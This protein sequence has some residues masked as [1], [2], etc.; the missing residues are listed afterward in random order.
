MLPHKAL[1][2]KQLI[3]LTFH[4]T[5]SVRRSRVRLAFAY[6]RTHLWANRD[7]STVFHSPLGRVLCLTS[8]CPGEELDAGRGAAGGGAEN[9][10]EAQ[11][12]GGFGGRGLM[13]RTGEDG[14]GR[15]RGGL[16][17]HRSRLRAWRQEDGAHRTPRFGGAR[18]ANATLPLKEKIQN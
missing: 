4:L 5:I 17:M 15:K 9:T 6:Q 2:D 13:G 7:R 3:V 10:A 18:W 11:P 14:F 1:R 8:S 12:A 16:W